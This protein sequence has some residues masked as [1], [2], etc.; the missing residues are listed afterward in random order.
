VRRINQAS[1]E[2]FSTLMWNIIGMTLKFSQTQPS[3]AACQPYSV[4]YAANTGQA[5]TY[6]L[7]QKEK[8]DGGKKD[9]VPNVVCE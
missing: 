4:T 9:D 1:T 5:V 8:K 6:K 7:L 3:V 2:G